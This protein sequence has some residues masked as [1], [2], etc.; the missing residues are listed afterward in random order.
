MRLSIG[1]LTIAILINYSALAYAEN[2]ALQFDGVNDY[3]EVPDS[4]KLSGYS[5]SLTFETWFYPTNGGIAS[6][7]TKYQD[8]NNK[9]WGLF[10]D[11]NNLLAFQK[12]TWSISGSPRGNWYVRSSSAVT[13]NTWNYGA[14]VFDDDNDII[15]V[16]L[17]GVLSG[18]S[19]FTSVLPDTN[20]PVWFGGP[21]QFYYN[22]YGNE[23][24]SGY[25]DEARLWNVARTDE[26]I[27]NNML[28]G[29]IVGTEP[30]LA[31][32]WNFDDGSGQVLRDLTQYHND[33]AIYGA[34]WVDSG[35][36][37]TPEPATMVLFSLGGI[38]TAFI[39]RK[40]K[41]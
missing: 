20:A 38:G 29:S 33:G 30:G 19:Q 2:Y 28:V 41:A 37:T 24:F 5:N 12:E 32:Y 39:R 36:P 22:L 11:E 13:L 23:M 10:I 6:I 31:A 14:F 1:I 34:S 27:A 26:E 7:A 17:N 18:S 40:R 25:I 4:P 35:S 9:D 16:Y 3:V 8:W 15:K 21:G